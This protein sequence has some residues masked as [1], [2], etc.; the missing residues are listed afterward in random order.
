[1][2]NLLQVVGRKNIDT[3]PQLTWPLVISCS[4]LLEHQ[5]KLDDNINVWLLLS[6]C[7]KFSTSE[8]RELHRTKS[9]FGSVESA[10]LFQER[11]SVV[12]SG[13]I[14]HSCPPYRD[15]N[16]LLHSG[17][18]K[19]HC[20]WEKFQKATAGKIKTYDASDLKGKSLVVD[21]KSHTKNTEHVFDMT[22]WWKHWNGTQRWLNPQ[23]P[24]V[25]SASTW[26][27]SLGPEQFGRCM[28]PAQVNLKMMCLQFSSNS[29]LQKDVS[30]KLRHEP[31]RHET[32]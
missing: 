17:S 15:S 18:L 29:T 28:W 19:K 6:F 10:A 7:L 22:I 31:R 23:C 4:C 5:Q 32:L 20:S 27:L 12:P 30:E 21:F 24:L 25:N 1:M 13:N 26:Y 14:Q 9:C 16:S 3:K 8:T 2:Q 11:K